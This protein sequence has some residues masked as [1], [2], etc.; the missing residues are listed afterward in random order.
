[1]PPDEYAIARGLRVLGLPITRGV[2]VHGIPVAPGVRGLCVARGGCLLG[3]AIAPGVRVLSL[4]VALGVRYHS[5]PPPQGFRVPRR[6]RDLRVRGPLRVACACLASPSNPASA[7]FARSQA[8]RAS[9]DVRGV[10]RRACVCVTPSC[11]RRPA[12]L[13]RGATAQ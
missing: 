1:M 7:F 6:S 2:C 13:Q 10:W 4:L 8:C 12:A 9:C 11:A 3:L 5:R